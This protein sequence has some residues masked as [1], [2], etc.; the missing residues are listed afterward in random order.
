MKNLLKNR[1]V[2]NA[3]VSLPVLLLALC[4]SCSDKGDDPDFT[5]KDTITS[6][7]NSKPEYSEF[8]AML[9]KSGLDGL[10]SVYGSNTC[11]V[12]TNAAVKKYYEE[13]GKTLSQ[14]TQESVNQL[15]KNHV[16]NKKFTS[17]DFPDGLL[18]A[19]NMYER[20]LNMTYGAGV[21]YVNG[22]R[23]L[24][25]DQEMHNG[26]IHTIDAVLDPTK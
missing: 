26:V 3:I 8:A 22:A 11:F 4:L 2:K 18:S 17:V 10:L 6:F 20:Y 13:K 1:M 9:K 25:M 15:V 14:I 5:K 7:L 24:I 12:P 16:I 23:I 19:A 21:I